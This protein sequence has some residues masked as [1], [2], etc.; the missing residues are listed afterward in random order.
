MKKETVSIVKRNE[1]TILDT[2]R[3]AVDLIGG[4]KA[5]VKPGQKVMLKPNCTGPL[6]SDDGAVTSN[7]VLE[8]IAVLVKEAGAS[9]IDI[10]EG[11]GA[12]H[13][14][15]KRIY[16]ALGIDELAERMG[17]GLYDVNETEF[18][19]V[20][21]EEFRMMDEIEIT[22]MAWEY[23]L[24]INIPV[25]KTHPL[26]EITVAY[27]NMNGLLS[28]RDKRRFHDYNMR[29]A[30]V[31][32]TTALPP[33]LTIVDGL[34][35]MEGLGPLEGTPVNLNLII[36]GSCPAAVDATIARIMG[37]HAEKLEYLV[38]AER[39]GHGP[40]TEEMIAVLGADIGEVTYQ[41]KTAEPDKREYE[42][43][44]IFEQDMPVKCYGCRAVMTIALTRIREAGHLPEFKGM[45]ILLN[46]DDPIDIPPLS[47]GEHLF[48]LG[49]CTKGFYEKNKGK[50][51]VHFILGCAPAGLT[52]EDAFRNCYGIERPDRHVRG[53]V[54]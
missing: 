51:N 4:M 26:T 27:K 32:L 43:I 44:S 15:T 16:K 19:S 47:E 38:E 8:S 1:K 40:I 6:S 7:Q 20:K 17:I 11:S 3:E 48:C 49:N 23:D 36:A 39:A 12:F 46:G 5:F 22:K 13:L 24:I 14:G 29:K 25:I 45:Q 21:N 30:V 9:R 41:F 54:E 42:G 2:V 28:P 50:E 35:A 52:T 31:D 18:V 37:F 33:Y 10:V 34:T 53:H